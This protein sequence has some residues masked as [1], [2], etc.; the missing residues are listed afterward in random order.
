VLLTR[1][2]AKKSPIKKEP[3]YIERDE[4]K[5]R[6]FDE[7]LDNLPIDTPIAYVDE[8]GIENHMHR[9]YGRSLRGQRVYA[10]QPGRHYGRTNVVAGLVDGK[11]IGLELY[12]HATNA[13]FFTA[14]FDLFCQQLRPNTRI[15]MD[16]ASF[17][18]KR[19]LER[20]AWLFDCEIL[21]LPPYSPDKNSIEHTWANLKNWLRLHS[22]E[23]STIQLAISDFFQ[24]E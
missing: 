5:R 10:P 11:I 17:H 12:N 14:W 9:N 19:E 1:W 7:K 20:I 6:E 16:N 15:I 13:S 4:E 23:Y 8:C 2:N 3:I 24:S 21:W 22:N 18:K